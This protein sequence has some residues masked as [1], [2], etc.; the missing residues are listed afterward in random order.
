MAAAA[1]LAS[2]SPVGPPQIFR[3]ASNHD[4]AAAVRCASERLRIEGFLL[5]DSPTGPVGFRR[6]ESNTEVGATEWW[7]VAVTITRDQENRTVVES[8]AGIG[9]TEEGP[10]TE[11]SVELQAIVGKISASCTW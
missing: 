4:S 11:P 9:P 5:S 3:F 1:L 10:F 2:C 7:R 8:L 6:A